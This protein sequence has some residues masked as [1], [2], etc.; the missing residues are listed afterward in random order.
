MSDLSF[1]LE[2]ALSHPGLILLIKVSY[3][4]PDTKQIL[5]V[6][7]TFSDEVSVMWPSRFT[8]MKAIYFVNRYLP[9]IE[10][11]LSV[12]CE[13]GVRASNSAGRYYNILSTSTVLYIIGSFT[14]EGILFVRT[15]ALWEFSRVVLGVLIALAIAIVVPCL[16]LARQYL[17]GMR[18]PAI[19]L[20]KETGCIASI[21]DGRSVWVFGC[22][23]LSETAIVAL[24]LLKRYMTRAM[25][26]SQ[27][28]PLLLHTMYRD[29]TLFYAIILLV[30]VANLLCMTLA[31][32]RSTFSAVLSCRPFHQVVHSSLTSRVLLNLRAA[33]A[34]SSGL[35]LSDFHRSTPI[36]FETSGMP[37]SVGWGGELDVDDLASPLRPESHAT[38]SNEDTSETPPMT[39]AERETIARYELSPPAVRGHNCGMHAHAETPR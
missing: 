2:G 27:T 35:S 28:L 4:A 33:A 30:S 15:Y 7:E 26:T 23:I 29:G 31:P 8:V 38:K 3:T 9:L 17:E 11:A 24:T 20:L 32:V 18:Y 22:I 34:R 19:G 12:I 10:I 14:S 13:Y 37:L 21:S 36:A 25:I 1:L 39:D 6:T 5:D 16:V